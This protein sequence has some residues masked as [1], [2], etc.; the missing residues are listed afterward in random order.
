MLDNSLISPVIARRSDLLGRVLAT[1]QLKPDRYVTYILT[2][3]GAVHWIQHTT[4]H[5]F[6][7]L[8]TRF[9]SVTPTHTNCYTMDQLSQ[10]LNS[11]PEGSVVFGEMYTTLTDEEQSL[12]GSYS[13]PTPPNYN[14]FLPLL[15]PCSVSL[16]ITSVRYDHT[17][18]RYN[19]TGKSG[20]RISVPGS[21][22]RQVL[23]GTEVVLEENL[24]QCVGGELV[25]SAVVLEGRCNLF[26]TDKFW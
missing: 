3:S 11:L 1:I 24:E 8:A 6:S 21:T 15:S 4:P 16:T 5:S 20:A 25:C 10:V 18:R 26:Q 22:I 13:V 14:Q 7:P 2:T 9:L 23:G 19:V 17:A 12:L